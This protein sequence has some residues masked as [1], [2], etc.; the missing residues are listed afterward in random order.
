LIAART[1]GLRLDGASPSCNKGNEEGFWEEEIHNS[2]AAEIRRLKDEIIALQQKLNEKQLENRVFVM[3]F[4]GLVADRQELFRYKNADNYQKHQ[5]EQTKMINRLQ[6][7]FKSSG[8]TEDTHQKVIQYLQHARR[9]NLQKNVLEILANRTS[10]ARR[11]RTIHGRIRTRMM[12]QE[13]STFFN[14]WAVFV[15]EKA[16][17]RLL[18]SPHYSGVCQELKEDNNRGNENNKGRHIDEKDSETLINVPRLVLFSTQ[19]RVTAIES[20]KEWA[21]CGERLGFPVAMLP[22][23]LDFHSLEQHGNTS[24]SLNTGAAA[25]EE[26]GGGVSR[27]GG[28]EA[29]KVCLAYQCQ[30]LTEENNN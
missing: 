23:K 22:C 17:I 6:A 19:R 28:A 16:A 10:I 9:G 11:H 27:S 20:A 7:C 30:A 26:A 4:Q 24:A 3:S 13:V 1:R 18:R 12:R 29:A 25:A 15:L 2:S 21:V 14:F 5:G 8:C